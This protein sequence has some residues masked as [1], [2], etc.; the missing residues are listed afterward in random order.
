MSSTYFQIK[1]A[2]WSSEVNTWNWNSISH[3]WLSSPVDDVTSISVVL[4][5]IIVVVVT[6]AGTLGTW[7][8]YKQ[9]TWNKLTLTHLLAEQSMC[10]FSVG[11]ILTFRH[12]VSWDLGIL[13]TY[14]QLIH[15]WS[16]SDLCWLWVLL[17]QSCHRYV[18]TSILMAYLTKCTRF[19]EYVTCWYLLHCPANSKFSLPFI[20]FYRLFKIGESEP[21]PADVY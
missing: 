15:N 1:Y 9:S 12:Q 7:R 4:F 13:F 6:L 16:L 5:D 18:N 17:G 11:A 10:Y 21:D 8:V 20:L 2:Q 19:W 14:I 3:R